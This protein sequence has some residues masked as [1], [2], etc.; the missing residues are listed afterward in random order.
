[1][2]AILDCPER[3]FQIANKSWM[4]VPTHWL[5]GT[6]MTTPMGELH[7]MANLFPVNMNDSPVQLVNNLLFGQL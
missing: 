2:N 3:C 4:T 5:T 6:F 7:P 1:M